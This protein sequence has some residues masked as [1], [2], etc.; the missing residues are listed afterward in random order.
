LALLAA[1][2]AVGQLLFEA[3]N[4]VHDGYGKEFWEVTELFWEKSMK[5]FQAKVRRYGNADNPLINNPR[6]FRTFFGSGSQDFGR[7]SAR[8]E[9]FA[10]MICSASDATRQTH[11]MLELK[12]LYLFIM[13]TF[14]PRNSNI[15]GGDIKKRLSSLDVISHYATGDDFAD[16][17]MRSVQLP[18]NRSS[19]FGGTIAR[20]QGADLNSAGEPPKDPIDELEQLIGLRPVKLQI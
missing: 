1:V 4:L 19:Y 11:L 14:T 8:T 18:L 12:K 20:S 6:T 2:S 15:V 3:E 13:E 16:F 10:E 5:L 9:F 17:M 7:K